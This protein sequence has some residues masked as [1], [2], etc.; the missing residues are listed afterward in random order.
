MKRCPNVWIRKKSWMA[1]WSGTQNC[2]KQDDPRWP[3]CSWLTFSGGWIPKGHGSTQEKYGLDGAQITKRSKL[4]TH[5]A[6]T[7]PTKSLQ[8]AWGF[9][10]ALEW[11]FGR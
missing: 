5:S 7:F 9:T 8:S 2:S 3:G 11:I 6:Q 1:A 4:T 10:A